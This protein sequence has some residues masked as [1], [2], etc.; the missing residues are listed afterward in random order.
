MILIEKLGRVNYL[1]RL[2]TEYNFLSPCI[3]SGMRQDVRIHKYKSFKDFNARILV[4]H[5]YLDVEYAL[6]E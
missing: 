6:S 2:L 4:W 1:I 5:I 3:H